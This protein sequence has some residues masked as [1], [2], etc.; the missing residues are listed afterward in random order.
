MEACSDIRPHMRSTLMDWL[1]EVHQ[2]FKLLQETLY[3][4]VSIIDRYVQ[5]SSFT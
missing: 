5:V 3:L 4:A 1:I 2:R